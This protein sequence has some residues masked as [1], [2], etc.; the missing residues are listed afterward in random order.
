MT[1]EALIIVRADTFHYIIEDHVLLCKSGRHGMLIMTGRAV[2]LFPDL[3]MMHALLVFLLLFVKIPL[4]A[5][6]AVTL[7]YLCSFFNR[8][9][10]VLGTVAVVM[11]LYAVKFLVGPF[12]INFFI[13]I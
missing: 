12:R 1:I 2:E 8:A 10:V 4:V 5:F 11:A 13:N 6:L 7:L 9:F 3:R